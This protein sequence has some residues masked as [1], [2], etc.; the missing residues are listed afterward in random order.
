MINVKDIVYSNLSKVCEN[1]SDLYPQSFVELPAVQ[2]VEEENRVNEYTDDK[3][4]SSYIRFRIDIWDNKSTSNLA[5]EIDEVMAMLGFYRSSCSDVPDPSQLKHKQMRY[6]A[7]I[8]CDKK[9]I[10]HAQY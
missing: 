1:L 2:Y 5:V 6:E 7:I 3:E 10:Y 4:Q 9:Y 8:D